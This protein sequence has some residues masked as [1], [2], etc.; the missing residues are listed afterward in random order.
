MLRWLEDLTE[1]DVAVVGPKIA[2]LQTLRRLG[3]EVPDGFAITTEAFRAFLSESSLESLIDGELAAITNT[4]DLTSLEA[5]AA[6]LRQA[7]EKV[8]LN[9]SFAALLQDAY[10]ELCFRYGD[11]ALP[12]AVRSSAVGEDAAA[13]SFAGQYESYLG[14]IG[15]EAVMTAVRKAWSSLFVARALSYRLRQRQH[16]R[17]T[18][19]AVG[20]LRLVHARCAGVG[21]SADPVRKKLDRFVVEGSWGWGEAIVQG[22]VEPDHVEIDR[23]DGRV[24]SYR[25]GNKKIATVFDRVL[26]AV[27][28]KEL[29]A[30][31]HAARCLTDEMINALWQ[32]LAQ[33]ERHFGHPVDIEWVIEPNWRPGIPVS[34]V[35][36]RPITTLGD[37]ARASVPPKWDA[38]DYAAKY[39]LGI[40]PKAVIGSSSD[41][42]G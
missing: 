11:I 23:A 19:M 13:A 27:A 18:P 24:I 22:T 2:R 21:F 41:S 29:P 33:I 37:E 9:E 10:H 12:V 25:V 6:R 20:V 31:F 36:V 42:A 28:E 5:A 15:P 34:I 8:P 1:G 16:Y 39:G 3:I 38:L 30:R 4:D 32:A 35:Q 7:I 17:D 14:I 26:G 40:K